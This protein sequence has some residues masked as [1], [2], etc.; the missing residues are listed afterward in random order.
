MRQGPL[1]AVSPY[2]RLGLPP[3]ASDAEVRA[4]YRALARA[5][6]PDVNPHDPEASE[7]FRLVSEAYRQIQSRRRKTSRLQ[8]VQ[9]RPNPSTWDDAQTVPSPPPPSV[10]RKSIS[11]R[12]RQV[13]GAVIV[14]S[15]VS[16]S[17]WTIAFIAGLHAKGQ[18][19]HGESILVLAVPAAGFALHKVIEYVVQLVQDA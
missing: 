17:V 7:K 4:A 2:E 1:D 12:D 11:R 19:P 16:I 14:L 5:L 8:E 6:H 13:I 9:K 18:I 10:A 15:C 3:G